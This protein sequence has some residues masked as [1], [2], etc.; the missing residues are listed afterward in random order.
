MEDIL[1]GVKLT[2]ITNSIGVILP[3]SFT[4]DTMNVTAISG[5]GNVVRDNKIEVIGKQVKFSH[6]HTPAEHLPETWRV[7][8]RNLDF[9]GRNGL[10]GQ[11]EYHL[12]KES[13]TV[14]L[15]AL[16]GLGGVGKTQLALEFVW[17]HH[18]HYKGV[19]WFDA[20]SQERLTEDYINLG[21]DLNIIHKDDKDAIEDS[22]RQVRNWLE[23]SKSAGWLLVY[24]NAPNYQAIG[25]LIPRKGGKILVTSRYVKGWPQEN[26]QVNV[27][28]PEESKAYIKKILGDKD[29]DTSQVNKLAETLGHLPLALA[30]ACAYIKENPVNGARYLELYETRKKKLLS[31]K[32]LRPDS[33]PAIVYITWDI[34]MEAICKESLLADKWLTICAFLNSNGIPYFLL[35]TFSES[36]DNNPEGEIFEEALGTLKSYS[37]LFINEQSSSASVHRLVQEVILLKAGAEERLKNIVTLLKLFQEC[38]PYRG[39]TNEDYTKKRQLIP[40]LEAFLSNLDACQK[41]ATLELKKY[42]EE[43]CLEN[44][45]SLMYDGYKDLGNWRRER[46]MLERTL[47]IE[48]FHYG[49]DHPSTLTTRDNMAGVLSKQGKY[50]EALQAYREVFDKR[51]DLLG[52]EHPDTLTTRNNM[53]AV[54]DDQGKYE[55]ALQ[56]YQEVFNKRK[57]LLGPEHPSTSTTWNNMAEVFTKQGKYAEALQAYQE[58]FDNQKDLLVPEHPDTLATRT[59][60][61][62]D[63]D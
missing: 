37:M 23:G 21:L 59:Y 15:T 30:Q 57:D 4:I 27:F 63:L 47:T 50:E 24:D 9:V 6:P 26:I 58:V 49:H 28:T 10:L 20:E 35:K 40:H 31:D 18:Q 19:A 43:S 34:T 44:V 16:N 2:T 38:F 42:I 53:A 55:E 22:C 17:Q 1:S 29:L 36:S 8:H 51:K 12:N 45:L 32:T 54:L 33:N 48:E 7:P 25:N 52:P 46:G 39:K 3:V 56:A 5:E 60:M 41:K 11:I 14:I 13:T 61:D 62:L